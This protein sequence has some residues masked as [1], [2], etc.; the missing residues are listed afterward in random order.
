MMHS[1]VCRELGHSEQQQDRSYSAGR[2]GGRA[3]KMN[4]FYGAN[5][6]LRASTGAESFCTVLISIMGQILP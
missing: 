4:L 2:N 5:S 1:P 6:L 3:L